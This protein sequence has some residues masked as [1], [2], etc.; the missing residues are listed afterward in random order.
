MNILINC[1][2]LKIGG[3]LQV[4]HS[5]LKEMQEYPQHNYIVVI[6]VEFAAL[7]EREVF[8]DNFSL[9]LY[10][11]KITISS[12]WG[13][14]KFLDKIV[15]DYSIDKALTI[16]GPAYWK[17]KV[18]HICGY[19]KPHYVYKNSP[20]FKDLST[21]QRF[22]LKVKEF[23]HL[24]FFKMAD[25]LVTENQ[26]VTTNLKKLIRKESI[27][28]ITNYYNQVFEKELEWDK[29][30]KLPDFE[31]TTMLTISANY[32]HKNL[33][34]IPKV[35]EYL[36]YKYPTFSFR[37]IITVEKKQFED[38]VDNAISQYIVF[39]GKVNVTSCPFLYKQSDI[40]FLPTLLE[41]FS[42]SYAE[43]M[44]MDIPILTS[45]LDFAKGLCGDAAVYFD[46]LSVA[47]IADKIHSLSTDSEKRKKLILEG[48]TQLEKFDNYKER[49]YKYLE[50]LE[51]YETNNTRP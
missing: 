45:D 50:L 4:A 28:T 23:L 46:P 51:N 34:V 27:Y 8:P 35:V 26:D 47:D 17:P 41:C 2:T 36:I 6:S 40:M 13:R 9:I 32:P 16:F 42:A 12:I 49:A 5:I 43:A 38:I 25:V 11:T 29:S 22:R 33:R 18:Q 15:H 31:G 10:S 48:H 3:G 21:S 19:A 44:I 1:S 20:F 39:L 30:L 24:H 37:F 14:N 7:I